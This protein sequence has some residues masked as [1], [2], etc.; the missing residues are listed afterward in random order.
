M[1][2][3]NLLLSASIAMAGVSIA[4][5]ASAG[6]DPLLGEIME[7]GFN[8]CPR[9]WANADGQLLPI[10]QNQALFSLYG[11]VYGG[12]GRSS[13]GLPD[14]RGRTSVHLGRGPGLGSLPQGSRGGVER[15]TVG[16]QNM[17]SHTHRAG[18]RT[19]I[20]DADTPTPQGN[21]FTQQG[22]NNAYNTDEPR[23]I[24]DG[25]RF[26]HPNTIYVEPTGGGQAI[27]SRSPYL[28]TRKCVA[29]V[30]AFPSRN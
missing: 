1:A 24:G 28:V 11:T 5:P 25:P 7:V 20:G 18:I 3:R 29:L 10:N 12:D 6:A 26:M 22:T 2:I 19:N 13:F 16:T 30:G 4:S 8:F 27:S 14:L 15:I 21:S 23:A 17:P 9:G